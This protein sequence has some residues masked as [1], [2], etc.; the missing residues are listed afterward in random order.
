MFD[1]P[2]IPELAISSR[3]LHWLKSSRAFGAHV[4]QRFSSACSPRGGAAMER[5]Q[6][7]PGSIRSDEAMISTCRAVA[8]KGSRPVC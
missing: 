6:R 1:Q 8:A 3:D 2:W 5:S 7:T 4:A